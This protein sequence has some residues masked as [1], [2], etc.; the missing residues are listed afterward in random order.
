MQLIALGGNL[1]SPLG[2]PRQTL[3]R[4][5][6]ELR[7]QGIPVVCRSSWYET[8]A[9]PA[10]SGPAFVN[11]VLV[12]SSD[13]NP[14]DVL[15]LLHT[16]E[17][18]LGRTRGVRWA[19]RACDLDLL[20]SGDSVLPDPA[21]VRS[22]MALRGEAAM[23]VPPE[24]VLPHPRMHER[25]FVLVPLAEVAPDWRHPVTGRTARQMLE[26]LPAEALVGIRRL[27]G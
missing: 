13:R 23:A 25:G 2:G 19:P 27:E 5:V 12:A 14:G 1:P 24:L 3:E 22:W 9:H 8:P 6:R 17:A 15:A 26:E 16:I 11:G 20:A 18:D 7:I 10:G 21:T 4:A